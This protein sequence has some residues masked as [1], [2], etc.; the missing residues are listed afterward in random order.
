M[1]IEA[2]TLRQPVKGDERVR[3]QEIVERYGRT[4]LAYFTLFEDKSYFFSPG[5]SVVAYVLK[6]RVAVVLGDPIGPEKDLGA[7]LLA[8]KSHCAHNRW[9][10]CYY[11][12]LPDHLKAYEALGFA[13]ITIGQEAVV[14]LR[15]LARKGRTGK[16][17]RNAVNH[18][19]R[20]G[21]RA[22]VYAPPLDDDVLS[23]LK[24]VSDQWLAEKLGNELQF[25]VG[26]FDEEKVR[27]NTVAAVRTEDGRM[28]AFANILPVRP[29]NRVMVDLM[30][31]LSRVE[32]G[33][34]DFLFISAFDW[35]LKNGYESFSLGFSPL[36]G[37]GGKPGDLL[38]ERALHYIHKNARGIYTLK[39]LHAFKDKFHPRWESRYMIFPGV[40][41]LP[42]VMLALARAHYGDDFFWKRI[43]C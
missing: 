21:Y 30:R 32:N 14:E 5:G 25:S 18:L 35:A 27:H 1:S 3:A 43:R 19:T 2:V 4:S 20:L 13:K 41:N 9:R 29:L 34:M 28:T 37:V 16:K 17:F 12:V 15:L 11:Q 8:F 38:M 33:T 36:S 7:S 39:G 26:W 24:V 40:A 31:H 42:A 23:E 6:R 22:E 10:A